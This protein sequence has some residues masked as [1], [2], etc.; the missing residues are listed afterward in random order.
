MIGKVIGPLVLGILVLT[1]TFGMASAAQHGG[2]GKGG[3]KMGAEMRAA[4][5]EGRIAFL[6]AALGIKENQLAAWNAYADG[7]R[8]QK[9]KGHSS[10]GSHGG[11]KGKGKGHG[12][13]KGHGGNKTAMEQMDSRIAM[14]QTHIADLEAL[15]PLATA[16]YAVLDDDQKK[17]ANKI[18]MKKGH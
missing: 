17:M 3:G 4:K 5:I 11:G 1:A 15:K 12:D 8:A 7:L 6:K 2:G 14:M 9:H 18:L 10:R 13:G 16:L